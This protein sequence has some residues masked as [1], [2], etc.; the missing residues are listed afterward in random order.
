MLPDS[1]E[2]DILKNVIKTHGITRLYLLQGMS[3]QIGDKTTDHCWK[4][5]VH[6]LLTA[7]RVAHDVQLERVFWPSSIAVF[8]PHSPRHE[9]PQEVISEPVTASGISYL[10]GEHWCAHYFKEYGIDVRSV[11]FPVIIPK[12][13]SCA[14]GLGA[15]TDELF[16]AA[17]EMRQATCF[18]A[19]DRCLPQLY[20]PDAVRAVMQLME[21]EKTRINTRTSYNIGGQSFAPCDLVAEIRKLFPGFSVVYEPDYRDQ[22]AASLPVSINDLQART[23][24]NWNPVYDLYRIAEN[25]FAHI[26]Q[27]RKIVSSPEKPKAQLPAYPDFH[28]D[29]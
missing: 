27:Q 5:N 24:W 13:R 26:G 16:C 22:I 7:L 28:T 25:R 3:Y 10:A 11:R 1:L 12:L 15:Y 2:Q 14:G 29:Y 20:L 21:V 23:D 8:G 19:E 17:A 6:D 4:R 18:L 9:C